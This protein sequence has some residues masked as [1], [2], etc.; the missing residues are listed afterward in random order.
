M[1]V[2]I[3]IPSVGESITE[4]TIAEWLKKD[5]DSVKKGDV[6]L[7]LETD[8]ASVELNAEESGTLKISTPEGETVQ[9]GAV[10]GSID[11]S[12]VSKQ[13]SST[14]KSSEVPSAPLPSSSK[15]STGGPSVSVEIPSV[16]ES[17]T[18][19]TIAEWHKSDGDYV[20]RDDVLMTLETDKASV[21]VNAEA[22]GILKIQVASGETI[23]VGKVVAEIEPGEAPE[24]ASQPQ[25][26]ASSTSN[27]N[28]RDPSSGGGALSTDVMESLSPAVRHLV[29]EKGIDPSQ[30]S[31]TGKGGRLTKEDIL[32]FVNEPEKKAQ[33]LVPSSS[34][35][36]A[37]KAPSIQEDRQEIKPMS[38]IRKTIARRLKE[39]QNT[40]AILTTFNEVD[41]T[42][43]IAMR[44]QY[45][46]DFVKKYDVK[47]GFMSIFIKA[48]IEGL[49]DF[50]A[51]NAFVEGT[52]LIY[53]HF[54][55]VGVAVSTERGLMVPVIKD[56]DKMTLA[57][58]ELAIKGFA[59][60]AR[61][62]KISMDD[63]AGGTFSVTNGG[64]F[65]SM[66]STPI[67]NPP[68]SG[69]LGMH[70][71][72]DRAVVVDGEIKIRKMMYLALSYDHRVVDGREAV[73]FLLKV[74]NCVE[75]PQRMLIHV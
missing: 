75:D 53:N 57:E 17:I 36:G 59:G 61:E 69:I 56:A 47:L 1:S 31:G 37:V 5:G 43:A 20:Q 38:A 40:A 9:V 72:Q 51:V 54:Y 63:L 35:A 45:Q 70:S 3:K 26:Q 6:L 68:Q 16:G 27:G 22:S 7:T 62:G 46:D 58:I 50:P 24:G 55:N 67:L 74:K 10:I 21:E 23:A 39:V 28:G 48:C 60:K 18:E 64:V 44:K 8:K 73:S 33:A 25:A 71:M 19:V 15:G 4:V 30:I 29:S 13:S 14:S 41:L 12:G 42:A 65:G 11:P 52:N 2:E 66:L 34:G 32:A 49:Q